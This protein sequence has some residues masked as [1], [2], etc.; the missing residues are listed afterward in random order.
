[1]RNIYG[2]FLLAA[3]APVGVCWAQGRP[4]AAPREGAAPARAAVMTNDQQ[5]AAFMYNCA[6]NEIEI[7]KFAQSKLQS[8]EAKEFAERMVKDHEPGLKKLAHLAGHLVAADNSGAAAAELRRDDKKDDASRDERRDESPRPAP[9]AGPKVDVTVRVGGPSGTLDWVRVHREL[10]EGGLATMKEELQKKKSEEFDQCYMGS[11]IM[12]H[13][14]M[15]SEIKVLRNYA[16]SEFRNELDK[17]AEMAANH[18]KEAK[19]IMEEQ[20]DHSERTTRN[21]K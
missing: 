13:T 1:M 12:A 14:F 17:T 4:G 15:L 9:A 7:S 3:L 21:P 19:R 10:A 11:Q 5:I 16:S 8:D 2:W 18:L 6:R 20:R